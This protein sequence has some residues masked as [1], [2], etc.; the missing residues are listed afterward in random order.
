MSTFVFNVDLSPL[1]LEFDSTYSSYHSAKRTATPDASSSVIISPRTFPK[2]PGQMAQLHCALG[3]FALLSYWRCDNAISSVA[4]T[5]SEI[6]LC[7]VRLHGPPGH[8]H[9]ESLLERRQWPFLDS[10]YYLR[11][12]SPRDAATFSL[13]SF[14]PGRSSRDVPMRWVGPTVL[15]PKCSSG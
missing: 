2:I 10:W 12:N 11:N 4:D 3:M 15:S 8:V 1:G 6:V 9:I 14:W 5:I 13:W 7:V